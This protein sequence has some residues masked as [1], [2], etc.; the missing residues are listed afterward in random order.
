MGRRKRLKLH[1]W[2]KDVTLETIKEFKRVKKILWAI[3]CRLGKT[4]MACDL[5]C[6]FAK[7]GLRVLISAYNKNEIKMGWVEKIYKNNL[8][9]PELLQVVISKSDLKK[10][11]AK[12]PGVNFVTRNNLDKAKPIS[13]ILP[14]S[15]NPGD[16][17]KV[18]LSIVD[19]A[20]E[21][22]EVRVLKKVRDRQ[23]EEYGKLK[24]ILKRATRK[25]TCTLGLSG[26]A[27]DLVRKSMFSK[28]THY[29]VRDAVFAIKK[30]MVLPF[31]VS[32]EYFDYNIKES[33]YN[34]NGNLKKDA[35]KSLNS[36]ILHKDRLRE[37]LKK[38]PKRYKTLVIVPHG[39]K[40]VKPMASFI[41]SIYGANSVV[42]NT[43]KDTA[44]VRNKSESIFENDPRCKFLVVELMCGTG[45]DFPRLDCV[46]DLS[47]TR[48]IKLIMQRIFRPCTPDM[49]SNGKS[50]KKKPIYFYSCSNNKDPYFFQRLILKGYNYMT[51]EG[52]RNPELA[53]TKNLYAKSLEKVTGS[54][55]VEIPAD[56]FMKHYKK[57]VPRV[58]NNN[59]WTTPFTGEF[60]PWDEH[61]TRLLLAKNL[62]QTPKV[63][64]T[65]NKA[66]V[67]INEVKL[68]LSDYALTT[69]AESI[70][71]E[72][73][74]KAGF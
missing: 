61:L 17:G 32:M 42:T 19:E 38:V 22:L 27:Q 41:E 57:G 33:E 24:K 48:N 13:I 15:V 70:L 47:F 3:N 7:Q 5:A 68:K 4:I 46:V 14:Q 69:R 28:N 2:Q 74:N 67:R 21:Y 30:G 54:N 73:L 55:S 50:R 37:I 8:I 58:S 36:K 35:L 20:H 45:W 16:V 62:L 71:E 53:E 23:V 43:Y 26:T 65:L 12:Y 49:L 25:N 10:E 1:P 52:I 39:K 51:E 9:P 18:D 66:Q 63:K 40:M 72:E 60:I 29:I 59:R 56:L 11:S 31:A 64:R 44:T 34:K 6:D